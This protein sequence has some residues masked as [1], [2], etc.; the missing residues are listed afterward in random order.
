MRGCHN[1]IE[2]YEEAIDILNRAEKILLNPLEKWYIKNTEGFVNIRSGNINTALRVFQDSYNNIKE[3]KP[4]EASYA[5]NNYAVCLMIKGEYDLAKDV[6]E[7]ALFWNKTNY[8]KLFLNVHY[9]MCNIFLG[10][11]ILAKESME[12]L[13][14]YLDKNNPTDNIIL[15]KLYMN[16]ALA[17]KY[18]GN[19][20]ES[21][22]YTKKV[23]KYVIN[24][25]SEFRYNKLINIETNEINNNIYYSYSKFDPWFV[26][27]AH[28]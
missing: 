14:K 16:L 2:D 3:I 28:D 7:D 27:Y 21:N 20:I 11:D 22:I 18:Q 4:Y 8:G 1:F 9:M 19:N 23:K 12:Y 17:F 25:S 5:G 15:R 13:I 10:N 24:T 6:L 26:V